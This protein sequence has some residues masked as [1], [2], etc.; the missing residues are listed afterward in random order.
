MDRA[1]AIFRLPL[2]GRGLAW[3]GFYLAILLAWV[4]VALMAAKL[5]GADLGAM[6]ASYWETLCLSAAEASPL[7]LLLMWALMSAAM[8]L[9]TFTPAA[10][11]YDDLR[12]AGAGDGRGL[13]ALV[14][15][16]L[17]V[18]GGASVLGAG[19]QWVLATKGLLTPAGASLSPI[20]TAG[21]LAGAGLYQFSVLKAACLS[22]CRMPMTFFMERWAQGTGPAFKMGLEL[23]AVCLGCCWALMLLG[24]VGGAMNLL[25]I[26]AATL[27]MT[28]EKL[29]DL[30]RPLTRPAGF[31]L[32]AAAAYTLIF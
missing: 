9:P 19:L 21:L 8:M 2:S 27:F 3:L 30:G 28:L 23:G 10:R 1:R 5:P 11:T 29:P 16:Y 32:L 17:V 7:A 31:A 4:S 25:W 15:G 18:W 13:A 24:F 14:G 20:L 6:P 12:S 22:K 26:G